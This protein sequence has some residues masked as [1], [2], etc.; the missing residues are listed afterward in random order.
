MDVKLYIEKIEAI[1]RKELL[2]IN[3]V[4]QEIGIAYQ[5]WA[6]IK[7]TP[8]VCALKTMRKLKAFVD[9]RIDNKGTY[10]EP[11]GNGSD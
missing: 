7:A 8:H 10:Y 4:M 2:S 11:T 5:T 3:E 1:R 6:R 9:K